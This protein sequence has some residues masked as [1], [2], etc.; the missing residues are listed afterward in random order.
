MVDP[1]EWNGATSPRKELTRGTS[2]SSL[3]E[4]NWRRQRQAGEDE[5]GWRVASHNRG[6][7]WGELLSSSKTSN[8]LKSLNFSTDFNI[9]LLFFA[10]RGSW[11]DAGSSDRPRLDRSDGDV[12]DIRSGGSAGGRWDQRATH[13]PS[14]DS[15]HH[16]PGR[17]SRT[18]EPNHHDIHDNLPEW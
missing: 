18:W 5:E 3:M 2:G 10:V 11:R 15:C 8:H 1:G 4:G 14:H 7:K 9:L 13:R 12:D 17:T 6:E 16:H